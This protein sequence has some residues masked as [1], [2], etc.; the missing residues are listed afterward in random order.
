MRGMDLLANIRKPLV[1]HIQN[2]MKT[3]FLLIL[4]FMIGV[5]AGAFTVN[6]LSTGQTEELKHYVQGFMN[7]MNNQKIDNGE[8]LKISFM[9]N[10]KVILVLWILGVTI[11]GAP[12]IFIIIGIR[13]FVTGFSSG[14]IV[15]VLGVKGVLFTALTLLPKELVVI[16]CILALGVSGINFSMN[17]VKKR[18]IKHISKEGLKL[19]FMSYCFVTLFYT[20]IIFAGVLIEAYITPFF[21]KLII[22]FVAS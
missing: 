7:L 5:S 19:N 9:E 20:G 22:P 16:P 8:L 10:A 3:Y 18:S 4:A 21:A 2:N 14:F 1:K 13:G 12:F 15:S 17:I 11:I 6:G